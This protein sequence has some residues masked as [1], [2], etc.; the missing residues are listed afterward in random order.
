MHFDTAFRRVV[1]R[2]VAERIRLDVGVQ[3][4]PHAVEQVLVEP[5]GH[6]GRVIIGPIEHGVVLLQIDADE[7]RPILAHMA[8]HALQKLLRGLRCQIADCRSREEAQTAGDRR[9]NAIQRWQAI[10]EVGTDRADWQAGI[11]CR[12][13]LGRIQEAPPRDIDSDI[14]GR[15]VKRIK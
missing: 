15:V 6:A 11:G 13:A 2:F 14:G 1:E 12:K 9:L 3:L 5:S 8:T 7:Q 10:D 4:P